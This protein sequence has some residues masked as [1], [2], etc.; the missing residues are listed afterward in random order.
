MSELVVQSNA[1][2]QSM[3]F[4]QVH[5]RADAQHV[6][7]VEPPLQRTSSTA[8]PPLG[9]FSSDTTG[10]PTCCVKKATIVCHAATCNRACMDC[11]CLHS[12]SRILQVEACDVLEGFMMLQSMA[13]GTG[14]G[15]GTY[16]AQALVDEY[17]SAHVLNC[18]VW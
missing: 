3:L 6:T 16:M 14:A 9:P 2:W 13:G 10:P 18:C 8:L 7:L 12:G 5:C 4:V 17:S 1:V 15:A 11:L